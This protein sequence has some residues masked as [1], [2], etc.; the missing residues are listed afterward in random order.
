MNMHGGPMWRVERTEQGEQVARDNFLTSEVSAAESI[1]WMNSVIIMDHLQALVNIP[2][3][4]ART[5]Q[6]EIAESDFSVGSSIQV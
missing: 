5:I 4:S 2:S 1:L 6:R 3:L